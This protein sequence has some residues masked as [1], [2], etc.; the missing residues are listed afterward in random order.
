MSSPECYADA[1]ASLLAAVPSTLSATHEIRVVTGSTSAALVETAERY[2]ASEVVIGARE[3]WTATQ[4]K[5]V[6]DALTI[7]TRIP[8]EVVTARAGT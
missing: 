1:I 4:S 5:G 7:Q 3:G 2:G 8:V 6:A